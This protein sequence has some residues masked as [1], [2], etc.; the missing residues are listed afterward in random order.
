MKLA[1]VPA[2]AGMTGLGEVRELRGI[3]PVARWVPGTRPA[4]TAVGEQDSIR[5]VLEV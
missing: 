1:R 2:F 5:T 4:M 3:G